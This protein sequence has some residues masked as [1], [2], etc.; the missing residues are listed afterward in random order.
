ME[1]PRQCLSKLYVRWQKRSFG[2]SRRGYKRDVGK[3]VAFLR[4]GGGRRRPI[5]RSCHI[6]RLREAV[7]GPPG[8]EL[9]YLPI[10]RTL[11]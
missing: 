5:A 1:L 3:P 4:A 7:A 11:A 6:R 10:M 8:M 2:K 9:P